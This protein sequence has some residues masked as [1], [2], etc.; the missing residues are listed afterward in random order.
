[1]PFS[2]CSSVCVYVKC[3]LLQLVYARLRVWLSE[4]C[5]SLCF[6]ASVLWEAGMLMSDPITLSSGGLEAWNSERRREKTTGNGERDAECVGCASIIMCLVLG[7]FARHYG[8]GH[9][10]NSV[11]YYRQL[12]SIS[13]DCVNSCVALSLLNK[14]SNSVIKCIYC[15]YRMAAGP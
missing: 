14:M 7:Y 10:V 8:Q 3:T 12:L 11:I 15:K 1:M 6:A 9:Y 13:F 2:L 5:A 4:H